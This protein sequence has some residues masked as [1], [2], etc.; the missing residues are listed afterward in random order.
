M[1]KDIKL[2]IPKVDELNYRQALLLQSDTMNYNKGFEIDNANYHKDTGCIYFPESQWESWYNSWVGNKPDYYYAYI[3][4][5]SDN[6][7]VG[8]VNLHFNRDHDWYE[9][10]IIIEEKYRGM[11]YSL[12]ALRQ[13]LEVAFEEFHANGV[14]NNFEYNRYAAVKTHV[15]SGFRIID[16]YE[17]NIDLYISKTQYF[18]QIEK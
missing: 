3:K 14:H 9:M 13:L 7:F 6:Q 8:E 12:C 1:R 16:N 17:G 18:D 4:R 10:G 2:Y 15:D 5:T 11:C